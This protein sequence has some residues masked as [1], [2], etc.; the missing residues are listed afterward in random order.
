M[1]WP[2]CLI[3]LKVNCTANLNQAILKSSRRPAMSDDT[4]LTTVAPATRTVRV[5]RSPPGSQL[6]RNRAFWRM[7]PASFMQVSDAQLHRRN[8]LGRRSASV[9]RSSATP[10]RRASSSSSSDTADAGAADDGDYELEERSAGNTPRRRSA[11]CSRAISPGWASSTTQAA[12][13]AQE[14]QVACIAVVQPRV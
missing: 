10:P 9:T 14:I 1:F 13:H 4:P 3:N 8:R 6:E 2:H 11:T 5:I 12:A 7:I